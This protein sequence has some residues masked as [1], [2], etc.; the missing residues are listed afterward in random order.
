MTAIKAMRSER[1]VRVAMEVW[2]A[3]CTHYEMIFFKLY[4]LVI[5]VIILRLFGNDQTV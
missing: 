1:L 4:V 3:V 5:E 2:V